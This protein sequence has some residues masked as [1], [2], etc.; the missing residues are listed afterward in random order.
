NDFL[1]TFGMIMQPAT[2]QATQAAW[3]KVPSKEVECINDALYQQGGSVEAL[4]QGRVA[5][6]PKARQRAIKLSE[7]IRATGDAADRQSEGGV[8]GRW[9]GSWCNSSVREFGI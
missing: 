6:R 8:C 5:I 3:A 9:H 1:R 2:V 7:T 4:I